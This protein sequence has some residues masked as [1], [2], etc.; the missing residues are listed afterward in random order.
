MRRGLSDALR[1]SDAFLRRPSASPSG[2]PASRAWLILRH[3]EEWIDRRFLSQSWTR[4][5]EAD[6][7]Y[8]VEPRTKLEAFLANRE[9]PEAE[10]KRQV[11]TSDDSKANVMKTVCAFANGPGGSILFGVD[12]DQGLLGYPGRMWAR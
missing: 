11:P 7:E 9:G 3:G 5:P 6:V 10:F 12:D 2:G 1:A 8:L 4:N